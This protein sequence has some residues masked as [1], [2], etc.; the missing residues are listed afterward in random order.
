[1]LGIWWRCKDSLIDGR[2]ARYASHLESPLPNVT[3]RRSRRRCSVV[4]ATESSSSESPIPRRKCPTP[5]KTSLTGCEEV[6]AAK[7][8]WRGTERTTPPSGIA[9][10]AM[11]P[12]SAPPR[13]RPGA[14][15][16][17]HAQSQALRRDQANRSAESTLTTPD[18]AEALNHMLHRMGLDEATKHEQASSK[19][20]MD[21]VR[22]RKHMPPTGMW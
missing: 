8:A 1:M 21:N 11:M 18:A 19:A 12:R 20:S 9:C 14:T 15:V 22:M 2:I 4:V 5:R 7:D 6:S 3:K 17:P 16:P 10:S 13:A